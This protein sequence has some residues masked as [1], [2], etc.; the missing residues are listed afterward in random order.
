MSELKAFPLYGNPDEGLTP[1]EILQISASPSSGEAEVSPTNPTCTLDDL[2][3]VKAGITA[4]N[5]FEPSPSDSSFTG[6]GSSYT[7]TGPSL[8]GTNS[9]L[10]NTGLT[11]PSMEPLSRMF[12]MGHATQTRPLQL[13]LNIP[14]LQSTVTDDRLTMSTQHA[15]MHMCRVTYEPHIT[16]EQDPTIDQVEAARGDYIVR[17][18]DAMHNQDRILDK[19]HEKEAYM[20]RVL[21]FNK[22][23]PRYVGKETV[24]S[25][26][27]VLFEVVLDRCRRGYRGDI[28]DD[29]A[30]YAKFGSG[31]GFR[32][33]PL[34]S[35]DATMDCKTRIQTIIEVLRLRKSAC[36][37]ITKTFSSMFPLANH[38]HAIL[39]KKKQY[40]K[41]ADSK[42][43]TLTKLKE[44]I[45]ERKQPFQGTGLHTRLGPSNSTPT[46]LA[47]NFA[48]PTQTRGGETRQSASGRSGRH[49]NPAA[50]TPRQDSMLGSGV[51][52]SMSPTG[53]R[54]PNRDT[55]NRPGSYGDYNKPGMPNQ[56]MNAPMTFTTTTIGTLNGTLNTFVAPFNH[57]AGFT[58]VFGA[59]HRTTNIRNI[60]S[61]QTG[62]VSAE[63]LDRSQFRYANESCDEPSASAYTSSPQAASQDHSAGQFQNRRRT[64]HADQ[65]GSHLNLAQPQQESP[66]YESPPSSNLDGYGG[67]HGYQPPQ[68]SPPFKRPFSQEFP[69]FNG[70]PARA[71]KKRR[72]DEATNA[73]TQA[74]KTPFTR[75]S[76]K[77]PQTYMPRLRTPATCEDSGAILNPRLQYFNA[78]RADLGAGLTRYRTR[79]RN[80][81]EATAREA[82]LTDMAPENSEYYGDNFNYTKANAEDQEDHEDEESN[83]EHAA[84]YDEATDPDADL[85]G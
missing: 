28:Q 50:G 22:E 3:Y 14:A 73:A 58:P 13:Y 79:E 9:L 1:K 54:A 31:G 26:C 23:S 78:L 45:E 57:G 37:E 17:L 4:F 63:Y 8:L 46:P 71:P 72:T 77:A 32:G 66:L 80:N 42:K 2:P 64:Q 16:P 43:N 12:A 75:N 36:Y 84:T 55:L 70:V 69:G 67:Y 44:G 62:E 25:R 85:F 34:I 48:H 52:S 19:R 21:M 74:Q 51:Q 5:L 49:G 38:P 24:E 33:A 35:T 56:E 7:D 65:K 81:L 61:V 18:M 20:F 59:N 47:P 40:G 27:H 6:I 68:N 10:S 30:H 82:P 53:G 29:F 11:F 60:K 15:F 83:D 76:Q 39:D 41:D